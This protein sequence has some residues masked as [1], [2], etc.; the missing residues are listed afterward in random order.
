MWGQRRT[1]ASRDGD[2]LV[3]SCR[4]WSGGG[5]SGPRLREWA[6]QDAQPSP[7]SGPRPPYLCYPSSLPQAS[8]CKKVHVPS[9]LSALFTPEKGTP[10]VLQGL[11]GSQISCTP[12]RS[13]A[14]LPR[15]VLIPCARSHLAD[16]RRKLRNR[17]RERPARGP[18][19]GREAGVPQ[20]PEL[21]SVRAVSG[22]RCRPLAPGDGGWSYARSPGRGGPHAIGGGGP[23][24]HP[25]RGR[26]LPAAARTARPSGGGGTRAL[27]EILVS[28]R[29][30]H[31]CRRHPCPQRGLPVLRCRHPRQWRR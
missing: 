21:P 28:P 31:G 3:R 27:R 22:R 7:R 14:P 13:A 29:V 15:N 5:D 6:A 25:A 11:M 8:A 4:P 30:E 1:W 19:G 26:P 2:C 24:A 17:E 10:K 18:R 16:P 12:T 9:G 20:D 23:S